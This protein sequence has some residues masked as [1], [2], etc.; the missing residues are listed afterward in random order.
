[1][2][3]RES[4][5]TRRQTAHARIRTRVHGTAERPRLAVFKSGRHVYVQLID[6]DRGQTLASASTVAKAT[7]GDIPTKG[8]IAAAKAVGEAIADVALKQSITNVVFDRGGFVYHGAVKALAE[9]ARAKGL[10]F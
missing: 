5:R 10:K 6:D 7:R 9:A 8:N 2:F 3:N 4:R 1:M